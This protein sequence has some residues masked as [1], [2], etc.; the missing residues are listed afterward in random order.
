[1]VTLTS[2][3]VL[4]VSQVSC[5]VLC[6]PPLLQ[7][8]LYSVPATTQANRTCRQDSCGIDL[9]ARSADYV[10]CCYGTDRGA[11]PFSLHGAQ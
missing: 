2:V 8:S 6:F 1:M 9:G 11:S 7:V 3:V 5:T 4:T 10:S